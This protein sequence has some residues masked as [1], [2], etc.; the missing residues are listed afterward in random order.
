MQGKIPERNLTSIARFQE[1]GGI[2]TI[3]SGRSAP[4][5]RPFA[6]QASSL[7]PAI[8]SNGTA[9]YDFGT[10]AY[11]W[12]AYMPEEAGALVEMIL[13]KFPRIGVEI[14]I[15]D[16]L[17]VLRLNHVI[18]KQMEI[19]HLSYISTSMAALPP[20]WHKVLLTGEPEDLQELADYVQTQNITCVSFVSSSPNYY[21]MLPLDVNK[22]TTLS[23]LAQILG[24]NMEQCGAIGDYFNDLA[25]L[26]AAG[27][28]AVVKG[29]PEELR[30]TA[31]HQFCS[32]EEG[33]VGEFLDYL[34]EHA[35][36]VR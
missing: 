12:N 25:L 33:A 21:E 23:V 18:I 27:I 20:H 26:Q 1:Q 36:K 11:L 10:D 5:I 17:Y 29:A 7:C 15:Q 14:Y 28:S 13:N 9:I 19:E 22:G 4:S 6:Q 32:A 34:I 16:E 24:V 8:V 30:A 2:F 35:G 31:T 3:A